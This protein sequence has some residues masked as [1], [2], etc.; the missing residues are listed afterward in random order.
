MGQ[1]G[2]CSRAGHH[3]ARRRGAGRQRQALHLGGGWSVTGPEPSPSAI[4]LKIAVPWDQANKSHHLVLSLI[5]TDGNPLPASAPAGQQQPFRIEADF[6]AGRPA[7]IAPGTPLDVPVALNLG[8]IPLMPG[9]RYV[10]VL[11]IDGQPEEA[12][13]RRSTLGRRRT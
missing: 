5:D 3:D 6:E 12:C 10:W 1:K 11:S 8:P 13:A 7:G 2:N 4:V 9:G